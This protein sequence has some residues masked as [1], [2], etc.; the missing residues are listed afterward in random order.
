M[1]KLKGMFSKDNFGEGKGAIF[2][3]KGC[4]KT[5]FVLNTLIPQL[6]ESGREYRVIDLINEYRNYTSDNIINVPYKPSGM[7][8]ALTR[9]I[10]DM[11]T[12]VF[13]IFD[14]ANLL[15]YEDIVDGKPNM[16]WLMD[17]LEAHDVCFIFE[18]I[19]HIYD[20]D[21]SGRLSEVLLF[22][23]CLDNRYSE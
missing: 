17:L 21:I 5:Y 2:G 14:C 20:V 8:S 15:M 9:V 11:D 16:N 19:K 22:E 10:S 1:I 6:K 13:L 7:K 18:R 3:K 4:G 23:P 12:N